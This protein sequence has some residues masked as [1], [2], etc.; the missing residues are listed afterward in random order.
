ME[1]M[2]K[3]CFLYEKLLDSS[4]NVLQAFISGKEK[5]PTKQR[6]TSNTFSDVYKMFEFAGKF[7][8]GIRALIHTQY[9]TCLYRPQPDKN[10]IDY[11]CVI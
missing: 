4:E 3:I 9:S 5:K 7:F 1:F 2:I 6:S 10:H 11:T 8:T